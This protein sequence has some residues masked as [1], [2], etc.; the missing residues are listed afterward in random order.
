MTKQN[1]LLSEIKSKIS[2]FSILII[3]FKVGQWAYW[4]V[5][6]HLLFAH[7]PTDI[8][9]LFMNSFTL[10]IIIKQNGGF[11]E[12][13]RER[14]ERNISQFCW[15]LENQTNAKPGLIENVRKKTNLL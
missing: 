15:L 4:C 14:E 9:M 5:C 8:E 2:F 3:L 12:K 1:T 6:T 11:T 13:Q 7:S 10:K